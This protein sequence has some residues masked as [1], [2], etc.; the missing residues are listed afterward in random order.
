MQGA[1]IQRRRASNDGDDVN[2]TELQD[3]SDLDKDGRL[4]AIL[5]D[6][7]W[8]LLGRDHEIKK[9]DKVIWLRAEET[10][11][12]CKEFDRP[13]AAEDFVRVVGMLAA[14]IFEKNVIFVPVWGGRD[15]GDFHWTLLTLSKIDEEWVVDYK[16]SLSTMHKDCREN[17][18]KLSTVL[19]VAM[20]QHGLTF[21]KDRSNRRFQTKG[22]G[23]CGQFVCHFVETKIREIRGEGP[24]SIG[25]ANVGRINTRLMKVM[26]IIIAGKGFAAMQA[27]KAQRLQESIEEN[28]RKEEEAQKKMAESKELL[29]KT[30]ISASMKILIPWASIAGC[31]KCRHKVEGSTCCNPEK[32]LARDRAVAEWNKKHGVTDGEEYDKKVYQSKLLEIYQEIKAKHLSSPV[33]LSAIPGKAGGDWED[34]WIKNI[35]KYIYIPRDAYIGKHLNF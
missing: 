13:D 27:K 28:K 31:P 26:Q 21:P 1:E 33:Q 15:N 35:S 23:L 18:E 25:N 2:P 29:E 20:N 10:S 19:A 24:A 14:K 32:I 11:A 17:A 4:P 5:L 7:W 16:D 12:V 9:T 34:R 22:S 6:L 8:Y 30:Q 3:H